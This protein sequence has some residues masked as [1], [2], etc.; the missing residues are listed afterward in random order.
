[1]HF[2][3]RHFT[4]TVDAGITEDA[5]GTGG[6]V[7]RVRRGSAEKDY[8]PWDTFSNGL[9]AA[10]LVEAWLDPVARQSLRERG[11]AAQYFIDPHGKERSIGEMFL[12]QRPSQ[13]IE[14]V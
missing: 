7:L 14:A 4:I 12:A 10:S 8:R 6:L 3:H 5:A 9:K 2:Y 1:M 11:F 13:P